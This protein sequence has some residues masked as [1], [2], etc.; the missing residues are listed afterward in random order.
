MKQIIFLGYIILSI[1][2]TFGQ[3]Q[4]DFKTE[5]DD[6]F[7]KRF[8]QNEPG[9]S[10]LVKKGN[11][12]IFLSNYGIEDITTGKKITENTLFNTG[13]I[14]KTFV[15]NGILILN[16]RG[17]LS[18]NDSI[19]KYFNDFDDTNLSKKVTIKHLLSH[20]SGLTDNRNVDDNETYY[21]T[22]K[23]EENFEPLKHTDSLEFKPGTKFKYSNPAYNGLALIIEK[24]TNQ[25]WQNFITENIFKPTNMTPST[26]TN[27]SYPESNVAHAY[28]KDKNEQ[29]IEN[30]YGEVPTF[31]A[32][33]NGGVWSSV[34]ELAKYEK[35]IQ[36]NV[37]LSEQTIRQS[38][39]TFQPEKWS[40]SSKPF[41]GYSW[42]LGEESLFKESIFKTDLIYHTGSQGGFNSFYIYFP[43]K[44]ILFIG[45]FNRPVNGFRKLLTDA[46]ILFE[47]NNWFD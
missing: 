44:D 20:T 25:P 38:R 3:P 1:N 46:V 30:D 33:G 7:S 21:L 41:I 15:A 43:K 19:H 12:T 22:A 27:G 5:F 47:K 35:A 26:I 2:T 40:E 24:L 45:L 18:L 32:A 37:F 28:I 8:K 11:E 36:E 42:F 6:L 9:G 17:L 16:E 13:S 31:A 39:T 10:I 34:L 23:D 4:N 14:S 29:F